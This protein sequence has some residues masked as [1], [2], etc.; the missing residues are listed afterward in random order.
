[1][2]ARFVCS[3]LVAAATTVT[4]AAAQDRPALREL[5]AG[6]VAEQIR[7]GTLKSADLV[8]A[9]LAAAEE[10]K[11]LN[12]IITLNPQALDRATALDEQAQL[13]NFAGALHGV[14]IVVKDNIASAGLP[15]TAGTPALR[16]FRPRE[17]AAI[18]QRLL[19]A[20][21]VLLAK[22]SMHELA[23][24]ITSN[25]A[26]FGAVGNAYAADRFAG[27]SSGGTATTIAARLAPV[28]LGTDTGGSVRIPDE[29]Y[30]GAMED[31]RPR[32]QKAFA[33]A[34]AQ[35]RIAALVFP[36]TPL[37][38]QPIQGSDQE[39]ILNGRKVPTFQT[40]IRNTDP[41]SNAGIPGLVLPA[42]LTQEGLPVG[43]ELDGAAGSDRDLLRIG[44]ALEAILGRVPAPSGR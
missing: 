40:F 21:A 30:R 36:A 4:A 27:G 25:N 32:L 28:G 12:A 29:V 7:S 39:V 24:G 26:S 6:D 23:F 37:P 1:M 8:K 43:I 38:A 14:P 35:H 16:E 15:T 31:A 42:G 17:N 44:L 18:L 33:D 41:G 10:R 20:G 2:L 11:K 22:T 34:F 3:L 5:G 19:D 9:L 13:G